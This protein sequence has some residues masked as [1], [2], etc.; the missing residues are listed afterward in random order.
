LHVL[1]GWV[2]HPGN[3][4]AIEESTVSVISG[5][6]GPTRWEQPV[7][8]AFVELAD[9]LTQNFDLSE[10]LQ[11]LLEQCRVLVGAREAGLLLL[12]P[13]GGVKL[14]ASSSETAD[15]V[16]LFQ[17]EVDRGPCLDAIATGTPIQAA[18]LAADPGR[19]AMWSEF[20]LAAGF[21]S[22][23]ASPMR[24][25]GQ[26][27]G[28]LDLFGS[29]PDALTGDDLMV[30]QALAD[31]ATIGILQYREINRHGHLHDQLRGA[32][33]SRILIEQAKGVI[34]GWPGNSGSLNAAFQL[35]QAYSRRHNTKLGVVCGDVVAGRLG[36]SE[37]AS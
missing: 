32:L 27:V 18:D 34:V 4:P 5:E 37:L 11:R 29:Q 31:I 26:T 17:L 30:V 12:A 21:H 36:T 25:R 3:Q 16:E 24:L 15:T 6:R 22:V 23:Y 1:T 28:A 13:R 8:R 33:S 2:V 35:L 9:T 7:I 20:A 19:W 14:A 10:F